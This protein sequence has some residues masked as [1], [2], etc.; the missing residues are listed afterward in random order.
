MALIIDT[1]SDGFKYEAENIWC[2]SAYNTN[3]SELFVSS[4]VQRPKASYKY[5]D[6][7]LKHLPITDMLR[8]IMTHDKIVGHNLLQHDYPLIRKLYPWFQLDI[9]NQVDDT[10]IMSS[11][12]NPDIEGGHSLE[13]WGKRLHSYKGDYH[14]FSEYKDEMLDYCIQ[15][16][17]ITAKIYR[18]LRS[19]I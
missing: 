14:D 12:L 17:L 19:M 11:L 16:T 7:L 8:E 15:D 2:I 6:K 5:K 18:V 4:V 1:E 13:A 9:P 10:M 3:K